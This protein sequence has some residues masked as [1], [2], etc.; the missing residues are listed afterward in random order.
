MTA[1]QQMQFPF[2]KQDEILYWADRYTEDQKLKRKR[3]EEDV[4]KIKCSV[5]NKGYLTQPNLM[6]MGRWK[7]RFTASEIK[8]ISPA[9]IEAVTRDAFRPG[10][11]WD[12]L[13]KLTA[14]E[15][16]G[17]SRASVILHLY[18]NGDY[19][20]LD[21]HAL[22]SLTIDHKKVDYDEKFWKKYVKFC[23]E[24]ADCHGV[25]MRTLDRALYKFSQ[26]GAATALKTITDDMFFLE[27]KR[28]GYNISRDN[29][30]D[31]TS[32][33]IIKIG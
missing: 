10:D 17:E 31:T 21:R 26:S 14:L 4:I 9:R 12:K 1:E 2:T 20:I 13:E 19:P 18:D 27:L 32:V 11:D 24:K 25:C 23:R 7:D 3:Q 15:G 28:R 30:E 6:E 22:W 29:R 8:N 5:E 33:G 16:I